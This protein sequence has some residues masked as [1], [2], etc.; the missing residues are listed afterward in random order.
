MHPIDTLNR[1]CSLPMSRISTAYIMATHL[2]S[3]PDLSSFS[4]YL[5][6]FQEP[7]A[8]EEEPADWP[9]VQLSQEAEPEG[10]PEGWPEAEPEGW[11][12]CQLDQLCEP[13]RLRI[14]ASR[15]FRIASYRSSM[16]A[17]RTDK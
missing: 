6:V 4:G 17:R 5:W 3:H 9:A 8:E 16:S 2:L 15:S 1:C 7:Q 13:S 12:G 11:P 14:L 10:W